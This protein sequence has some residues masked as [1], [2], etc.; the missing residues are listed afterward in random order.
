VAIN[1]VD[2][3]RARCAT[4]DGSRST[5]VSSASKISLIRSLCRRTKAGGVGTRLP[6]LALRFADLR[7]NIP[8]VQVWYFRFFFKLV[9]RSGEVLGLGLSVDLVVVRIGASTSGLGLS[10]VGVGDGEE[11]CDGLN[12]KCFF[13]FGGLPDNVTD[14]DPDAES[15]RLGM[16]S[17]S[18]FSSRE[19]TGDR[20]VD[21]SAVL[22]RC[23]GGLSPIHRGRV[24]E[25]TAELL[26]AIE[27]MLPD[28][29]WPRTVEQLPSVSEEISDRGR[30][31]GM[32][33]TR[34]AKPTRGRAPFMLSLRWGE[35]GMDCVIDIDCLGGLGFGRGNA[36]SEGV[37]G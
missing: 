2:F 9:L 36:G 3:G 23:F 31:R 33:S 16:E 37:F 1:G 29:L 22:G 35:D 21:G 6:P 5:T 30:G 19:R 20:S 15:G 12:Q 34:S 4:G 7:E 10:A 32:T 11:C 17:V 26:L 27:L 18:S 25:L 28:R 13:L 24:G 8:E 14:G